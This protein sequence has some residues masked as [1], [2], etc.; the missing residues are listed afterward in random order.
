MKAFCVLSYRT[1]S[2][3]NRLQK[4]LH[5]FHCKLPVDQPHFLTFVLIDHP[6]MREWKWTLMILFLMKSCYLNFVIQGLVGNSK[7]LLWVDKNLCVSED[8]KGSLPTQGDGT[9]TVELGYGRYGSHGFHVL[10][11]CYALSPPDVIKERDRGG[12]VSK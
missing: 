10:L 7:M 5:A 1:L 4:L 11:L 9:G 3:R 6:P 2:C 8:W 12:K